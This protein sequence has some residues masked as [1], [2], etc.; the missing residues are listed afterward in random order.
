MNKDLGNKI[1]K[2]VMEVL[3]VIVIAFYAF[4][5][6]PKTFQNDTYYTIKIGEYIQKN[7]KDPKQLLPWNMGLYSQDPFSYHENLV[8]TYPHWFYDW[9]TYK[10]YSVNGLESVYVMTCIFSIILGLSIYYVNRRLN[11]NRPI[12]AIITVASL[13]CL[14]GFIA[15][16]AQLVTFSLFVL[17]LY[18][19]ERFIK[20]RK[21]RY[22]VMLVAIPILIANIHSAVWP[23]YFVLY[24]PYLAQYF[25][26][27][28]ATTNFNLLF[29]KIGLK[30]KKKKLSKEQYKKELENINKLELE[31]NNR[32]EERSKKTYK[33][34]VE[35][36]KNIKWL[37]LIAFICLFTGLLTPIKDMPYTYVIRIMEGNTT[38]SISEHLPLTLI[39]N[40]TVMTI[41]VIFFGIITFTKTKIRICDFFMAFGLIYLCLMSQRQVSMLVLI[42]NFILVRLI[43]N[44]YNR[45][46]KRF[47]TKFNHTFID[48][49][50]VVIITLFINLTS[51]SNYMMK[52]NQYY[53][54]A[55]SYPVSAANYINEKLIPSVGKEN[56]RLFNEYNYGSYLLY[57]NIP[58]FI[59]SRCDL[60]TPEFNGTKND[61]G[62][63]EGRDIFS[64]F[65]DVSNMIIDYE[66]IFV[67][68]KIT[69]V[70]SYSGNKLSRALDKD[71]NYNQIY[72][73]THFSIY[74]RNTDIK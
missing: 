21:I 45:L 44:L 19:I 41:F 39:K 4:S 24:L 8:Y 51:I 50:F 35:H 3:A 65:M 32:I 16:R 57:E 49:I 9:F 37:F 13:Y 15:A 11:K 67:K 33:L 74:E 23:F 26:T 60:Y 62:R 55:S 38:A 22:A 64:D 69:H 52:K 31:H 56:L 7:V 29:K 61:K 6:T 47:F 73:D 5:I 28:I 25:I 48:L 58:V 68:Y 14:R 53:V 54:D 30:F 43:C 10:A 72:S 66:P 34:D 71:E 42:G 36:E 70:I 20:T 18:G 1:L 59:D 12:S 2:I 27:G 46:D 17:A 63:Y 40:T